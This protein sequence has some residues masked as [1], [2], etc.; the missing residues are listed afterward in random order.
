VEAAPTESLSNGNLDFPD[1][2]IILNGV[3]RFSRCFI[4]AVSKMS[5]K[6]A[7]CLGIAQRGEIRPGYF[8][9]IVLFNPDTIAE[10]TSV[11][12]IRF[13]LCA[14]FRIRF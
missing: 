13:L 5:G 12:E 4:E 8:A 11:S 2:Q 1:K 9:E 7:R 14:P 10:S 6:T 3:Q